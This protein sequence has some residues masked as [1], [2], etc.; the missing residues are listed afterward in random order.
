MSRRAWSVPAT[1]VP[2]VNDII[3]TI[4]VKLQRGRTLVCLHAP[5]EGS[6]IVCAE[7]PSAGVLCAAC[8]L[9]HA[10]RHPYTLEHT[11]DH[12]NA[13]VPEIN[14]L[15]ATIE[16][17]GL[18]VTTTRGRSKLLIGPILVGCIGLCTPCAQSASEQAA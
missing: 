17:A 9:A 3:K 6:A 2:E 8:F 18:R 1:A 11:C 4:G 15:V 7:H 12:C 16:S 14:T 5:Q 10:E 13:V